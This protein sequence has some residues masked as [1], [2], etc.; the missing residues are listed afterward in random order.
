[1]AL[2]ILTLYSASQQQQNA[3]SRS[4]ASKRQALGRYAIRS[5]QPAVCRKH[6]RNKSPPSSPFGP[7]NKSANAR[8]SSTL[9]LML[10]LLTSTVKEGGKRCVWEPNGC[11]SVF[12]KKLLPS[13][14]ALRLSEH[15]A[16][17][18]LTPWYS[19]TE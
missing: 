2:H 19:S 17:K 14:Q 5:I 7:V 11:Y 4:S 18:N 3:N 9:T 1:M 6:H 8:R 13:K 16:K 12:S 10:T 15:R